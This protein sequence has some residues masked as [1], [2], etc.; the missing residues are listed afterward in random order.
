MSIFCQWILAKI[1]VEFEACTSEK[2]NKI[3]LELEDLLFTADQ[4]IEYRKYT[5][6]IGNLKLKHLMRNDLFTKWTIQQDFSIGKVSDS[7][8]R[9]FLNL[10]LT[11]VS[12]KDFYQ[13]IG[14]KK[15]F[16]GNKT[17]ME[18]IIIL[19]SLEVILDLDRV[20]EIIEPF[21]VFCD[22][23]VYQMRNYFKNQFESDIDTQSSWNHPKFLPLIHFE[24]RGITCYLSLSQIKDFNS[25]LIWTIGEINVT[26]NLKNPLQR[27]PL[28]PDVFAKATSM[29]M[30]TVPG[31]MIEDRQYEITFKNISAASANWFDV[32]KTKSSFIHL[33][34]AVEWN[35]PE[36]KPKDLVL[37]KIFQNFELIVTYA[38]AIIYNNVLI[39]G[40]ALEF[41]CAVDLIAKIATDQLIMLTCHVRRVTEIMR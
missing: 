15:R 35:N 30:L 7:T 33:N 29:G 1:I 32:L 10:T 18:L 26:S 36:K 38:P 22:I 34:P 21:C 25:V 2:S 28:R 20:P 24:N 23:Y 31:A 9:P 41:N 8:D 16:Y 27:N 37:H 39:C 17:I 14:V 11:D 12:L 19:N 40:A 5:G 3:A 6:K 13:R 4:N